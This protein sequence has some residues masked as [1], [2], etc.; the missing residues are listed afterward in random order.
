MP[1][2]MQQGGSKGEGEPWSDAH[3]CAFNF[4]SMWSPLGD[5]LD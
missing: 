1:M 2:F 4:Y 3:P 5:D